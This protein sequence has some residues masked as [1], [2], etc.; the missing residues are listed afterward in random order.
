MVFSQTSAKG[1]QRS[2]PSTLVH[3]GKRGPRFRRPSRY[4]PN[5]LSFMSR[6]G[7]AVFA[8]PGTPLGYKCPIPDRPNFGL[9]PQR[10]SENTEI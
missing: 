6:V 3:S 2:R 9:F 8:R 10:P 5:R 4:P 1:V 7:W